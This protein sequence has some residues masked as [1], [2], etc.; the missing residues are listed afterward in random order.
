[1][2][3]KKNT[4]T[5]HFVDTDGEVDVIVGQVS[6]QDDAIEWNAVDL[7]TTNP[8]QYID[9]TLVNDAGDDAPLL[10]DGK[11]GGTNQTSVETGKKNPTKL[12]QGYDLSNGDNEVVHVS[13]SSAHLLGAKAKGKSPDGQEKLRRSLKE[14]DRRRQ[15]IFGDGGD[16]PQIIIGP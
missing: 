3:R 13:T 9:I 10:D 6:L 5:I 7:D 2:A 1:M 12:Y 4:L 15:R 16:D 8:A 14:K 11:G